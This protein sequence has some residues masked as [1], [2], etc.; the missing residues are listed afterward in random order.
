MANK[1]P[2]LRIPDMPNDD[3][4]AGLWLEAFA[5]NLAR[6][7]PAGGLGVPWELSDT[8]S[9]RV[10]AFPEAYHLAFGAS[11]RTTLT[12]A[13]KT[14]AR[15]EAVRSVREADEAACPATESRCARN[16][17]PRVRR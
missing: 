5:H 17:S 6:D 11:T 3:G 8:I 16:P 9:Q 14:Q 1:L 2:S 10:K 15:N 13:A 12:V 4:R 7:Y